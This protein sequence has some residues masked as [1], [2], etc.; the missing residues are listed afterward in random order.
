MQKLKE[1]TDHLLEIKRV[2]DRMKLL[3]GTV[4][5]K[6]QAKDWLA[7]LKQEK[8]TSYTWTQ[9]KADLL[10][11]YCDVNG[12]LARGASFAAL[13]LTQG[14]LSVDEYL[15]KFRALAARW[16]PHGDEQTRF[17]RFTLGLRPALA[18]E[19]KKLDSMKLSKAIARAKTMEFSLKETNPHASYWC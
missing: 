19:V 18:T 1:R 9:F 16:F 12:E 5:L 11:E 7:W 17:M 10:E 2:P 4:N 14:Q 3:E 13:T 8:G 6:G 15:Q